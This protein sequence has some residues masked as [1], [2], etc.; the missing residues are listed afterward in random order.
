MKFFILGDSW[1]LGEWKIINKI[2]TLVPDTGL[3]YYLHNAGHI[4]TNASVGC[5]SNF[6]QLRNAYWRLKENSNYDYIIWFHTEPVRDII[7]T[8]LDDNIDG[9]IQYPN[10]KNIKDYNEAITYVN[11]CNY[12]YA[13]KMFEEFDIPFIVIGGV[14]RLEDSIDNY[15]FAKHKIYSWTAEILNLDYKLPRNIYSRHDFDRIFS[16]TSYNKNQLLEEIDLALQYRTLL[17]DSPL[18]PDNAHVIR[19]EYEKLA[20]RLLK[21]I[22]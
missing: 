3:D 19:N 22:N 4:T 18:F 17:V 2:M 1:G 7:E 21:L 14:G 16:I 10:F 5:A 12:N 9:P 20:H 8:V 6:G 13:Q 11:E 15:A